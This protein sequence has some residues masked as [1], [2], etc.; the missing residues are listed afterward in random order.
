[1]NDSTV[2]PKLRLGKYRHYKGR[3]YQVLGVATHTETGELLVVYRYLYGDFGL[4]VRP[5]AMFVENVD[6]DG[7]IQP[8][9]KWI[10]E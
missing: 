2:L 7:Q 1:M 8:R 3:D 4:S 9:F 6:V 5:F 10:E